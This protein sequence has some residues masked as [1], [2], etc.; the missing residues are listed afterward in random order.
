[1][2]S[3]QGAKKEKRDS[4]K[5]RFQL[6]YDS[7]P[8]WPFWSSILKVRTKIGKLQTVL[9]ITLEESPVYVKT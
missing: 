9:K 7:K 6:L 3:T 2:L 5:Q 4:T 1:M 8:S